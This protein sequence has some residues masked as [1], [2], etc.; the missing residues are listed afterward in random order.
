[1]ELSATGGKAKVEVA[2][3]AVDASGIHVELVDSDPAVSNGSTI[4]TLLVSGSGLAMR[5][6]VLA[7]VVDTISAGV[8][9]VGLVGAERDVHEAE[10]AA[11]RLEV[12]ALTE[13]AEEAEARANLAEPEVIR[14]GRR[15]PE[16]Q[17]SLVQM[18]ARRDELVQQRDALVVERDRAARERDEATSELIAE[19]ER[20]EAEIHRM[21]KALEVAQR[22]V[23]EHEEIE[24]RLRSE[25]ERLH[26]RLTVAEEQLAEVRRRRG[27][28][29]AERDAAIAERDD[30]R[31]RLDRTSVLLTEAEAVVEMRP[32]EDWSHWAKQF[33]AMPPAIK[34]AIFDQALCGHPDDR[35]GVAHSWAVVAHAATMAWVTREDVVVDSLAIHRYHH[36]PPAPIDG[37]PSPLEIK[38]TADDLRYYAATEMARGA[39]GTMARYLRTHE[40]ARM[41]DNLS[42]AEPIRGWLPESIFPPGSD[43]APDT[44]DTTT[45]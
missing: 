16:V 33:D 37:L 9:K 5:Q 18:T 24:P 26:R 43:G 34:T 21:T 19:Q 25:G 45:P 27:E 40:L 28:I 35:P 6:E 13:R 38:E 44:E 12:A 1:M 15:L 41:L 22:Q 10:K 42:N 17:R 8:A 30:L 32:S 14:L 2:S 20:F 3:A 31:E 4:G 39:Q 7:A 29:T 36:A 11:L 23:R